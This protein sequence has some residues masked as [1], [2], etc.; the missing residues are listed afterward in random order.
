MINTFGINL[1]KYRREKN[2]GINELGRLVG[3]SG[4]YISS[5]EKGTKANP[6]FELIHKIAKSLDIKPELLTQSETLEFE[7]DS[8]NDIL[9]ILDL[10]NSLT[11]D[12]IQMSIDEKTILIDT[13]KNIIDSIR[14]KRLK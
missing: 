14:Y 8:I 2:I 3:V 11:L 10:S 9:K 6:S 7:T 1:N 12:D 13:L 4:A 5:L